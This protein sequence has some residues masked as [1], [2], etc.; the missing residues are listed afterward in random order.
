VFGAVAR[1][2]RRIVGASD[3]WQQLTASKCLERTF[4][5]GENGFTHEYIVETANALLN[6]RR[7]EHFGM[8]HELSF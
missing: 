3:G 1:A 7:E 6:K 2:F 5:R 8:S 4:V